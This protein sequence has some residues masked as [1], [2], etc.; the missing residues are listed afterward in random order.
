MCDEVIIKKKN[1]RNFYLLIVCVYLLFVL[2]AMRQAV[3]IPPDPWDLLLGFTMAVVAVILCITDARLMGKPLNRF[4]YWLIFF[5]WPVALL[6]CLIRSI[7]LRGLGIFALH[8]VAIIILGTVIL[9]IAEPSLLDPPQVR[10]KFVINYA[11]EC[12]GILHRGTFS[13]IDGR[14]AATWILNENGTEKTNKLDVTRDEFCD[15]WSEINDVPDFNNNVAMSENPPLNSKTHH[16]IEIV[17]DND[18][19]KGELTYIIPED[20]C[21]PKFKKWLLRIGYSGK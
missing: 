16:I 5:L 21:S 9:V 6:I 20:S 19:E 10:E 11:H 12:D 8:S 17:F 14:I 7:G 15:V 18:G 13:L 2:M 4:T 1:K 3:G